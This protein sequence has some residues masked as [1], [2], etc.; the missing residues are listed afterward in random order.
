[1]QLLKIFYAIVIFM[2]LAQ[3]KCVVLMDG[4][5]SIITCKGKL[6]MDTVTTVFH[7]G[8]KFYYG[9]HNFYHNKF[10]KRLCIFHSG[11]NIRTL[12]LTR[13]DVPIDEYYTDTSGYTVRTYFYH[14]SWE[15]PYDQWLQWEWKFDSN[16]KLLSSYNAISAP[17]P[18]HN[19][20]KFLIKYYGNCTIDN[21]D[22]CDAH[23]WVYFA[24]TYDQYFLFNNFNIT[25]GKKVPNSEQSISFTKIAGMLVDRSVS[26]Y[27]SHVGSC[28]CPYNTASNGSSCGERS[29]YSRPGGES[30]ICYEDDVTPQMVIDYARLHT[31]HGSTGDYFDFN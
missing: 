31:R 25:R 5:D 2:S 8:Q 9:F 24:D 30:P 12:F 26:R 23:E 4:S 20:P 1:M 19:Q 27:L 17:S 3:G 6:H 28:P 22:S 14:W 15:K 7:N 29:A 13:E 10:Y 18:G 21:W 16:G 11:K